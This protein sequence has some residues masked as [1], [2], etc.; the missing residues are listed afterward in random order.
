MVVCDSPRT[1]L[2]RVVAVSG[3]FYVAR[4]PLSRDSDERSQL[5]SGSVAASHSVAVG[6]AALLV[7]TAFLHC[8][9]VEVA[10]C[11]E[12]RPYV[13]GAVKPD[14]SRLGRLRAPP[15]ALCGVSLDQF[16]LNGDL[17]NLSEPVIILLMLVAEG[18]RR[19]R[20]CMSPRLSAYSSI[21][22]LP[23]AAAAVIAFLP[24]PFPV[25]SGRSP[26]R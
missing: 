26:A 19:E 7:V 5:L 11:I 24:R 25:G 17:E 14:R 10:R 15:A 2:D 4:R 23:A 6:R 12:Q 18:A 3:H 22:G 16:V 9:P 20:R 8:A 1:M 13:L 21:S